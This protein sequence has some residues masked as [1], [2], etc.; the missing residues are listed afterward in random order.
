MKLISE[1]EKYVKRASAFKNS[2]ADVRDRER[3]LKVIA[4]RR[5]LALNYG[6][7]EDLIEKLY[8]VMID[9][10]IQEELE[11]W[12]VNRTKSHSAALKS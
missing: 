7:S 6:T 10:F 1:R 4:S 9:H 11:E 2:E 3:V 5:K 12:K 8:T